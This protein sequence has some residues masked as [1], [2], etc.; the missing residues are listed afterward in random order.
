MN[1]R[2]RTRQRDLQASISSSENG[3]ITTP[4]DSP[5]SNSA[6]PD[7][8]RDGD[9]VARHTNGKKSQSKSSSVHP[10][11]R[12]SITR[13]PLAT[14]NFIVRKWEIP[15]KTLHVSIGMFTFPPFEFDWLSENRICHIVSLCTRIS[16]T[17]YCA[18]T[19]IHFYSGFLRGCH[20]VHVACFQSS[21][22][23]T[24][25]SANAWS[26]KTT[27]EWRYIL[28]SR[29]MDSI[30]LLPQSSLLLSTPLIAGYRDCFDLTIVMVRYRRVD[31]RSS[32]RE[33]RTSIATWKKPFWITGS[34]VYGS[35]CRLHLLG[36]IV[37]TLWIACSC[38]SFLLVQGQH[39]R[40]QFYT[41]RKCFMD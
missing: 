31:F 7:T 12:R 25:G 35:S 6:S 4:P 26:G 21:L 30:I 11:K 8:L 20:K 15:R 22:D 37:S 32:L 27:M 14:W 24:N 16:T 33:I 5:L 41:G 1:T 28:P 2:S 34:Y 9:A 17:R 36:N 18:V 23:Q 10:T 13:V 19:C 3:S 29:G 38:T 39:F 40:F